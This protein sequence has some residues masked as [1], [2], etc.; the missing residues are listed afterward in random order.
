MKTYAVETLQR[1][2][3]IGAKSTEDIVLNWS[4]YQDTKMEV[5]EDGN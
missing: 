2:A 5:V 1:T 3:Y 4:D